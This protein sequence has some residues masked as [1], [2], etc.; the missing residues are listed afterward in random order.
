[1]TF[2]SLPYAVFLTVVTGAVWRLRHRDQNRF[3]LVV[4]YLFYGAWD[5]R[6]LALL[7]GSTV[8]GYTAGIALEG[9]D[10][11]AR[12]RA[13]VISRVALNLAILGVFKYA[14]FFLSSAVAGLEAVGMSGTEPSL[15]IILPIAISYYT[16]EEISYTVDIYRRDIRACRDP[17]AYGLF[18][19]FFPKLVAGPILRP[20][21]L[22]PQIEQPRLRPDGDRVLSALGLLLWGLVKKVVIADTLAQLADEIYARP[23]SQS[24]LSLALATLCFAGQIYGDF[25]G[26]T[27]MARGAARLL[28]FEL[29]LNFRQP[30]LSSSLTAFW[31]TWHISLSSWLRDYLYIPLGGNRRGLNRTMVN[32]L[33]VMVLGGLWHGAGWTFLIWGAI[34]G[35]ALGAE[36]LSGRALDNTDTVARWRDLPRIVLT[37]AVVCLAWVFFRAPTVGEAWTIVIRILTLA[38]GDTV[39]TSAVMLALLGSVLV[40]T[41]VVQRRIQVDP[42]EPADARL[43]PAL[44]RRP[45][46]VLTGWLVG[47][48]VAA[49]VV[50]SGG[51]PVPFIYFQF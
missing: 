4:S 1:L 49:L 21:E 24:G 2:N 20:R 5:W 28:G 48:A 39:W 44:L 32:L 34:H 42:T 26:Y 22:L 41:D 36:R 40:V 25:S 15:R 23:G 38:P 43:G 50:T 7:V 19:A 8:I 37:F 33:T 12:R 10:D 13:I 47:V 3:L 46:P 18:V 45:R 17:V 29:P 30:Y 27:D 35:V 14:N 11:P 31:R 9:T 6:F 51:Q 16:F